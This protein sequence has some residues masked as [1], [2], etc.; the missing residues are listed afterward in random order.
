MGMNEEERVYTVGE[1]NRLADGLLQG[2]VLWVEG[3]VS[4]L[5]PYPNYT[6][7]SLSDEDAS[8][9]C[10]IFRE[11]LAGMA[12]EL[13]EGM[14]LLARG[15]LG[16]Y[17]RRGQFRLNVLEARESG[18]GRLRREFL[19]LMRKLAA[20]GLFDEALKRPL[21]AYPHTVGLITSLE[22]AAV[23]D[24]V[25]NL[26]RRFPGTRLLIRG[27]RVQG[28]EAVGDIV[29]AIDLFNRAQAAEVLILA[30]GGG[31]L[32]D[33]KPFNSEEVARAIRASSIPVVTGVG[34]EP[35]ITLSDLAAD[36]R[37]STPTGAAEAVVPSREE[38]L[39]LLGQRELALASGLRRGLHRMESRMG[40]ILAKRL[41]SDPAMLVNQAAQRL[42]DAEESLVSVEH[43]CLER[44]ERVVEAAALSLARFQREYRGLPSMLDGAARKLSASFKAWLR[45]KESEPEFRAR[46]LKAA[47]AEALSRGD[48][49]LRLAASRLEALSPLAVLSRGY[50]IVTREGETRPLTDSA[51][52]GVGDGLDIRL[53]RGRIRGEVKEVETWEENGG[54]TT[55]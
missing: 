48:G 5:R 9:S 47:V 32:E 44:R 31:S 37:A 11:A 51:A 46:E 26:T 27:V 18:E 20:E 8:L 49:R 4:N 41:F 42:A 38:V 45:W 3:E 6:F 28:D 13:R 14:S 25:I 22:G 12:G 34:H 7:F 1:V 21:P 55:G 33:L 36:F 53:H 29:A 43:A 39:N 35:D 15:R 17:V 52:V 19:L 50:A 30:R 10:I 54:N 16:V 23:R 24:V 40:S 2:I